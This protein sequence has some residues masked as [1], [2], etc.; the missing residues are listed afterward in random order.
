MHRSVSMGEIYIIILL[1]LVG[2]PLLVWISA[3]LA[4]RT[5][6]DV[7]GVHGRDAPPPP[8]GKNATPVTLDRNPEMPHKP[9]ARN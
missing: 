1:L 6:E 4:R 7:G 8:S 2:L 5:T 9:G 3:R